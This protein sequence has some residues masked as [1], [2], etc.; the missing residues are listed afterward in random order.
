MSDPHVYEATP[1][2]RV[3]GIR[4]RS[5]VSANGAMVTTGS[6]SLVEVTLS[7]DTSIYANGDVLAD[8]QE[9]TNFFPVAGGT[10][11]IK[12]VTVIDEDDQGTALDLYVSRTGGTLGTENAAISISDANAREVQVLAVVLA[13]DFVDTI[14]SRIATKTKLDVI[15]GGGASTSLWIGAVVRSGT[16]T[17]TASGLKLRMYVEKH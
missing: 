12:S 17:Y 5:R 16:P 10:A 9:I 11:T 4:T 13:A 2:T 3:D 8:F 7:T 14:N 15:V 1:A 6:I